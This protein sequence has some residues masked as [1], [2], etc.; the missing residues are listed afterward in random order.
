MSNCPICKRPAEVAGPTNAFEYQIDCPRCSKFSM[1]SS[2]FQTFQGQL[3]PNGEKLR[4]YLSAHVK[5]SVE[6]LK[7]DFGNWRAF[8]EVHSSTRVPEK[9]DKLLHL[10]ASKTNVAGE[11]VELYP[12]LDHP[13]IDAVS[14]D[15]MVYLLRHLNDSG[16]V[17]ATDTIA[18]VTVKGWEK[19]QGPLGG[20]PGR[21]FVAMSFDATL[22]DAYESGIR[23]AIK[24]D[25]SLPDP[26]RM[27][28]EHHNEKICD[29][30]IAEI[31]SCQFMVA[32]FTLQRAGVY[33][34]AGFAMG[35][36]RPVIW[37]C[38]EDNFSNLHF[39]TR[40]YNHIKWSTPAELREKLADRIRATIPL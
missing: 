35:L 16:F 32:D 23:P 40:Q 24:Q 9:A 38:R 6:M 37:S 19:V 2:L 14:P 34:E 18:K 15:E 12:M 22:D 4:P 1:A 30:I 11:R 5:Q 3:S 31:R 36:L 10:C 21:C 33:F 27:D 7:I 20:F 25:C 8:A 13:L 29:K 28:R 26:I 39:D 17:E